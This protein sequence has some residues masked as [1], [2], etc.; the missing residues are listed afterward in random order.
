V[1]TEPSRNHSHLDREHFNGS[2]ATFLHRW[3][4][5]EVQQ[6]GLT[7]TTAALVLVVVVVAVMA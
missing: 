1:A 5:L 4:G 3:P 7:V 6:A 2:R